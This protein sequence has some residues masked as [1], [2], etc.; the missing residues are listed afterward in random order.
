[1]SLT[2]K[3]EETCLLAEELASLTGESKT[4]AIKIALQQRLDRELRTRSATQRLI[5]MRK[6][7][8]RCADL[9]KPGPSAVEHGD[10]L[11]DEHGLP[12]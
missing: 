1:M 12:R 9:L 6:I 7:A 3:N 11:Y 10:V 2:I 8:D 5:E 4:S